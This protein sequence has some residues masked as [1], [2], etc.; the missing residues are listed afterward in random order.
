[1]GLLRITI[2]DTTDVTATAA[3]LHVSIKGSSPL[4]G[5][6]AVKKAAEVR[7]LVAAL[8]RAGL[9]EDAVEVQGIRMS[10]STAMLNR[11]QKVEILL[12]ITS[13]PDLLPSV[14]GALAE[15]PNL[16]LAELEWVFDSFEASIPLAAQAMR[17]AR[18]KADAL[19][20]AAGLTVAGVHNA[21]DSW[22]MPEP[23]VMMA[24]MEAS[25]RM[26]KGAAP[27]LDLG[28]EFSSTQK[29][30]VHLSVDFTVG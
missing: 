12:V 24:A 7:D 3:R 27:E 11:T 23:R 17:K 1:M 29:L 16:K 2:D 22:S 25:P 8:G 5:N 10:S 18:R 4:L 13:T 28:V 30:Y 19:A 9:S 21:S 20:E 26:A 14:L 6:A 15:A